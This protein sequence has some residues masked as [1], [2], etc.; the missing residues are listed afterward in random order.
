M[1][2]LTSRV[3]IGKSGVPNFLAAIL[4]VLEVDGLVNYGV[5]IALET[6]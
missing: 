2:K 4:F 6:G 1:G 3:T 5:N